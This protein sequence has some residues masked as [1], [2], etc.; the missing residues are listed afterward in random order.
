MI[1]KDLELKE[2][3]IL[4]KIIELKIF[5][6]KEKMHLLEKWENK[7]KPDRKSYSIKIHQ[8][9]ASIVLYMITKNVIPTLLQK[10]KTVLLIG[11]N[12]HQTKETT[13]VIA[14]KTLPIALNFQIRI[15]T[16]KSKNQKCTPANSFQKASKRPKISELFH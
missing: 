11:T 12:L 6:R 4:K 14:Q 2:I 7:I 15:Q 10:S 3:N 13:I 5:S 16:T 9:I 1:L 8:I